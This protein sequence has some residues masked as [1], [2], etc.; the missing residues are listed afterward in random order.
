MKLV[1]REEDLLRK[2]LKLRKVCV[3]ST[4][5]NRNAC[6]GFDKS[7]VIF[8]VRNGRTLPP[9]APKS[10]NWTC[11]VEWQIP[12]PLCSLFFHFW[13]L[14]MVT[15][16]STL[17]YVCNIPRVYLKG[18]RKMDNILSHQWAEWLWDPRQQFERK[19][20]QLPSCIYSHTPNVLTFY[21]DFWNLQEFL[22]KIRR[23]SSLFFL[24]RGWKTFMA[25]SWHLFNHQRFHEFRVQ[26]RKINL[27]LQKADLGILLEIQDLQSI[28]FTQQELVGF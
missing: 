17:R 7:D 21:L 18:D 28:F 23:M 20:T 26:W 11:A 22:K 27:N 13:K 19:G 3:T 8:L 25:M 15:C 10:P 6:M 24:E 2:M 14:G 12:L 16:S 5:R 9:F 1:F 4:N